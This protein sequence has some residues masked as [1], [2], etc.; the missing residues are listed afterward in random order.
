LTITKAVKFS[1]QNTSKIAGE[2]RQT[3]QNSQRRVLTIQSKSIVCIYKPIT[4]RFTHNT[5]IHCKYNCKR[6]QL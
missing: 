2:L 6:K 1:R 5:S 4:N 3:M